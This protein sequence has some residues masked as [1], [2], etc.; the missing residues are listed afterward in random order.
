MACTWPAAAKLCVR[1]HAH[2]SRVH[3]SSPARSYQLLRVIQNLGSTGASSAVIMSSIT[4]AISASA[5]TAA[6]LSS[7]RFRLLRLPGRTSTP[8]EAAADRAVAAV[9]TASSAAASA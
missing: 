1:T 5:A 3:R 9:A 2:R 6:A 4:P 8:F 7:S